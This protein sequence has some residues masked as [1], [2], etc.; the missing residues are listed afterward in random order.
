MP[1]GRGSRLGL[2]AGRHVA[3]SASVAGWGEATEG[4]FINRSRTYQIFDN[5]SWIHGNHTFKFGGEAASRRYNLIG[6]QFPRGLLQFHS[7]AT[8][9]P[10]D[11]QDSAT[12]FAS[13]LLGWMDEA[14]RALGLPNVQFRQNA[15]PRLRRGRL[16]GDAEADRDHGSA[17]RE[18]AAVGGPLPRHHERQAVLPRR[19][20]HRHR[21][22]LPDAGHGSAGPSTDFYEGLSVRFA[23]NIPMAA[24]DDVLFNHALQARDNNDFAPRLGIAYQLGQKTTIR[25]G[26]GVFYTQDTTNP[27]FDRA[28]NFGF[29]ESARGLD[30]RPSVNLDDPWAASGASGL[31]CSNWDG[32]CVARLY[33]FAG[34][35]NRRTPY[36]QQFMFNV[37]HQ[38]DSSTLLEVGY[39]GNLGTKIERMYGYN[40]PLDKRRARTDTTTRIQRIPWGD[41]YGR[42]QT[43]N[44]SST[45]TTTR[46]A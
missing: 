4:P 33:T 35:A 46:S 13:G 28:R 30:V 29:R 17:V 36:V 21:R 18:H 14:T 22:G 45:R 37:Q 41:E 26:Y 31:Q 5:M 32:V 10:T 39:S 8:A 38:L 7:R 20:R 3:A 2:A 11:L 23:D 9:L 1:V 25:T 43:I 34:D 19:G 16:E 40:T 44:P 27:M 42:I 6:N 24:G 12:A 15:I